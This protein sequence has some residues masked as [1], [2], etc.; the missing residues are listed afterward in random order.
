M[1]SGFLLVLQLIPFFLAF[2]C[3]SSPGCSS[4][5]VPSDILTACALVAAWS[6]DQDIVSA[7]TKERR[8][9]MN[10][11]SGKR[12]EHEQREDY[13]TTIKHSQRWQEG[14]SDWKKAATEIQERKYRNT[15]IVWHY[16]QHCHLLPAPSARPC[17]TLNADEEQA[18]VQYCHTSLDARDTKQ[19]KM[20]KKKERGKRRSK[21]LRN[22]H[23]P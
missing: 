13:T 16:S 14:Q 7:R 17:Q 23:D 21:T 2:V 19:L 11:I 1:C 3:T 6:A 15:T 18:R 9:R 12:H 20:S 5:S 8:R 22:N 4:T 10:D